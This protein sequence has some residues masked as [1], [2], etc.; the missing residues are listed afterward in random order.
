M[1]VVLNRDCC[2][3]DAME[4]D[5]VSRL[6]INCLYLAGSAGVEVE[7]HRRSVQSGTSTQGTSV[8]PAP[9]TAQKAQATFLRE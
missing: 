5:G 7:P 6:G 4:V 8:D 1:S 2:T 9:K 3:R